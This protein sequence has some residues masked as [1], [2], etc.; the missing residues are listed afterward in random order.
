MLVAEYWAWYETARTHSAMPIKAWY[1]T[2]IPLFDADLRQWREGAWQ[3]DALSMC[4]KFDL[5]H[6]IQCW[7]NDAPLWPVTA[8]GYLALPWLIG[9]YPQWTAERNCRCTC[10]VWPR[11]AVDPT[12]P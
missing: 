10:C 5:M 12:L 2:D 4:G 8:H 6:Y 9:T 11:C 3:I 7:N 1:L